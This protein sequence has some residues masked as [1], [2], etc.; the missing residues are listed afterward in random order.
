MLKIDSHQHLW[1]Y[2]HIKASCITEDMSILKRYYL[3]PELC[4]ILKANGFD[5]CVVVQSDQSEQ[6]NDFQIFNAEEYDFVKGIVGWV[7]LLS[8]GIEERLEY[9]SQFNK[10]KGF[11]HVLQDEPQRDFMLRPD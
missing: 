9:Y 5:G 3:P 7:D 10:L 11:R 1:K 4:L 8:S 6:E 2:D